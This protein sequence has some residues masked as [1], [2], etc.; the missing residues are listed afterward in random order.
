LDIE[1][2]EMQFSSFLAGYQMGTRQIV[3]CKSGQSDQG[4]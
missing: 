3:S 2:E 4:L 1:R